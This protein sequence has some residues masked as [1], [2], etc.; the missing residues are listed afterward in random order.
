MGT[1]A[2]TGNDSGCSG[3]LLDSIVNMIMGDLTLAECL[4][5]H[6]VDQSNS[7]YVRFSKA[8]NTS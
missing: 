8:K 7:I 6:F 2:L 1:R 3:M 5:R 4:L